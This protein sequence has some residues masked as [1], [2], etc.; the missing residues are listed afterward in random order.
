MCISFK[1]MRTCDWADGCKHFVSD[2]PS[3][4]DTAKRRRMLL[5]FSFFLCLFIWMERQQFPLLLKVRKCGQRQEQLVVECVRLRRQ[6][7]VRWMWL[8]ISSHYFS[9]RRVDAAAAA[10]EEAAAK[11][12]SFSSSKTTANDGTRFTTMRARLHIRTSCCSPHTISLKHRSSKM[13]L[14]SYLHYYFF[15]KGKNINI[16]LKSC[17]TLNKKMQKFSFDARVCTNKSSQLKTHSSWNLHFSKVKVLW[18]SV[19][20]VLFSSWQSYSWIGWE[21]SESTLSSHG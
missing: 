10:V 2:I 3:A 6:R 17:N 12:R 9:L 16:F 19:V 8:A 4:I 14:L 7:P 5:F 1:G 18:H 21:S 15:F 20:V 13:Q 11:I